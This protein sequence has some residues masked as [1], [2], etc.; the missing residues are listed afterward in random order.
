MPAAPGPMAIGSRLARRTRERSMRKSP[1]KAVV[2][3]GGS[4]YT[5]EIIEG[6]LNCR[7]QLPLRELW[8]VDIAAG[9]D[10]VDLVAGLAPR[11]AA[12]FPQPVP[13]KTA[14]EPDAVPQD[15]HILLSA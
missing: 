2:V 15:A 1:L 8:L 13:I 6:L 11:M 7:D 3:G 5:P 14:L 4:S 9:K 12:N 10:K